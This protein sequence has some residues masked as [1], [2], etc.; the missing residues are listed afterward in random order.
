[1]EGVLEEFTLFAALKHVI[2]TDTYDEKGSRCYS[3]MLQYQQ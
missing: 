1:M 3:D 2:G